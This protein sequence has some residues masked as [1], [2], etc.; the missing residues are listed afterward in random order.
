MNNSDY[1][2]CLLL[3]SDYKVSSFY[4]SK[5]KEKCLENN[6]LIEEI[7]FDYLN[8]EKLSHDYNG[9]IIEPRLKTDLEE[10]YS[11]FSKDDVFF[12]QL[13]QEEIL[14]SEIDN[15]IAKVL[16]EIKV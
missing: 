7:C 6:I 16:R 14:V 12:L 5:L 11:I 13:S 1:L 8:R 10:V 4:V 15:V 9:V 3:C 2:K